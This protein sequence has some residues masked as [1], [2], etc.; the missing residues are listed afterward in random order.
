MQNVYTFVFKHFYYKIIKDPKLM[1]S[2]FLSNMHM[3]TLCPKYLQRFFMKFY[4]EISNRGGVAL[5]N[6]FNTFFKNWLDVS[7]SNR[8]NFPKIHRIRIFL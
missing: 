3:W 4:S 7:F 2:E 5:T 1:E 6:C 8:R